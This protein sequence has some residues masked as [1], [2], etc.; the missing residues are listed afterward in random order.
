MQFDQLEIIQ[1]ISDKLE[2]E[3]M[4]LYVDN[5]LSTEL[6]FGF[7]IHEDNEKRVSIEISLKPE[8]TIKQ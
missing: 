2:A 3:I 6:N 7:I 4:P 5:Q 8:L 1:Q